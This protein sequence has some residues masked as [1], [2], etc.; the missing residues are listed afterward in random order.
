MAKSMS[1]EDRAEIAKYR[2]E[3]RYT[4]YEDYAPSGRVALDT[5]NKADA[6]MKGKPMVRKKGEMP[7]NPDAAKKAQAA[8]RAYSS[9]LKRETKHK[10]PVEALRK[11][12]S[13]RGCGVA[14]KGLTKGKMR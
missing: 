7:Y 3:K 14:R 11:G 5:Y 10:V 8:Q 9:E 13:V 1:D 2:K 4:G 6:E 12:G